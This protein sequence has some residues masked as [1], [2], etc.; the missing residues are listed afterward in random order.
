L[1]LARRP[2]E[3]RSESLAFLTVDDVSE[4]IR[5]TKPAVR[6]WIKVGTLAASRPAAGNGNGRLYRVARVDID[7]FVRDGKWFVVLGG[8]ISRAQPRTS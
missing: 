5:I 7:A 4:M 3:N 2:V 8:K 6:P 1:A